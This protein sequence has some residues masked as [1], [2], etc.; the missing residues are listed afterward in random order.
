MMHPCTSAFLVPVAYTCTSLC[1]SHLQTWPCCCDASHL[2]HE[3]FTKGRRSIQNN[4][5][6]VKIKV[7]PLL[8]LP[9]F[10]HQPE[11]AYDRMV[12]KRHA[13]QSSTM[14]LNNS[15]IHKKITVKKMMSQA[16]IRELQHLKLNTP[17]SS[18]LCTAISL[19]KTPTSAGPSMCFRQKVMSHLQ[20]GAAGTYF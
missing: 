7:L 19:H 14:V 15:R 9:I 5:I 10:W 6:T 8:S 1:L 20:R 17:C 16:R 3:L 11:I 13:I 2:L 12:D 18:H 4:V